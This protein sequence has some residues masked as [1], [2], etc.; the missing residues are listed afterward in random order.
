M[1][2]CV[3]VCVCVC[4]RARVLLLNFFYDGYAFVCVGGGRGRGGEFH[5]YC[6]NGCSCFN[7]YT[8]L[9]VGVFFIKCAVLC[10]PVA[11]RVNFSEEIIK[12]F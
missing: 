10:Y 8:S 1:C 4:A 6:V 12:Y 5:V 11:P 2:V 9:M 7:K 3:C